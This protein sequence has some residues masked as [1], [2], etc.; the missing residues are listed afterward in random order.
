[1]KTDFDSICKV[2]TKLGLLTATL[3]WYEYFTNRYLIGHALQ[4]YTQDI[5]GIYGFRTMVFSR[6]YLPHGMLLGFFSIIYF[7]LYLKK[8]KITSLLGCIYCYITILTTSS[9]GP[10]AANGIALFL[11]F[12]LY[13]YYNQKSLK[14]ILSYIAVAIGVLGAY[15]ILTSNISSDNEMI[16]YF[17][18]RIRSIID[19][20]HEGANVTRTIIWSK[21]I[22]NYFKKA[23]IFGIG[24]SKTG[25]WSYPNLSEPYSLGVTE[26]GMLKKLCELGIV[27]VTLYYG[28][29]ISIVIKGIKS[30]KRI[31]YKNK[32]ELICYLGL[33][34][35]VLINDIT[36]QTT[37][38]IMVSFQMWAAL[39]G[40]YITAEKAECQ[41]KALVN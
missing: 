40:I 23:P 6:S 41:N 27:G 14:K 1:M 4:S 34:T 9:R 15:I 12:I 39:A 33:L 37:E 2:L 31:P 8:K 30:F 26:S 11:M 3:S 16:N 32:V 17:L 5:G 21:S 38:E 22:E 13:S 29:I 25:S 19:W 36:L 24:A 35:A 10:L 18:T 28:F 7:Y 20:H